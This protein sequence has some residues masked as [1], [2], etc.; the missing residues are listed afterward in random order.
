MKKRLLISSAAFTLLLFML[1]CNLGPLTIDFGGGGD[2]DSS[3]GDSAD[4]GIEAGIN[5]PANGA[6]LS[7]GPTE[8]AYYATSVDGVASL[9]LSVNGEVL[10][11][12]TNPDTSQQVTAL[13]YSWEPTTAG[14]HTIRV[15][16]LDAK[17]NWSEYAI[18]TVNV[19]PP[20]QAQPESQPQ[21][22]ADA[23]DQNESGSQQGQD[24]DDDDSDVPPE[25]DV[26]QIYNV[27]HDPDTFYY[28]SSACGS[29]KI[30]IEADITNPDDAYAAIIFFRFW[31]KEG[32]GLS[33]W[34]SGTAMSRESDEHFSITLESDQ[35]ANYNKFEF[36]VMYYQ[37]KVQSKPP[38]PDILAGT[39]VVKEIVLEV[40]P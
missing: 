9:E 36:A 39:E 26:M 3:S 25:S 8:I 7:A 21:D 10:S 33:A 20:P 2:G 5:A 24:Q 27:E 40:C 32:E 29:K 30:T 14:S 12:V 31:D 4:G 38:N 15:R 16:A 18:V 1:A 28:G 22:Q 11:T 13:K 17:G 19:S 35:I 34:D 37:I 23:P 6:T